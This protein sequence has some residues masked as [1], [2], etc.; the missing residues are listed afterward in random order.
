MIVIG[1]SVSIGYTPVVASALSDQ[2]FVQHSPWAGGGGADDVGTGI[3]CELYLLRTSMYQSVSWDLVSFNFG[4]H[5][6]DNATAAENTYEALLENFT[7]SLV[8]SQPKAKLVYVTTT[9]YMPDRFFG[10]TVVEDLNARART[11]MGTRGI[12]VVDLYQHVI[13]KCGAV[14]K[15][16]SICDDEYNPV[17]GV[18]CGYHYS[19]EGWQ[20]LGQFLAPVYLSMLKP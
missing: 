20:Y 1:D 15:N 11:V 5:N 16:C 3:V 9:P 14:Y 4:L 18:T 19:A 8:R 6:L 7:D 12:P 17:T 13:D 2:V 10:N